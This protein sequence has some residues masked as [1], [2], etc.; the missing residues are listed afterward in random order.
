M[1][2]SLTVTKA[3]LPGHLF[4][5]R[6]AG[7]VRLG[8]LLLLTLGLMML[9]GQAFALTMGELVVHSSPGKPLR[10]S[11][12][13]ALQNGEQLAE[14][15]VSLASAESYAQQ[16]IDYPTFLGGLRI[17]LLSTGEDSARIQLFGEQ[18]WQGEG[19]VLMLKAVWPQ[20]QLS[21]RFRLREVNLDETAGEQQLR[22][23]EVTE[24]ETL[25]EIAMRLSA[26]TN[27]SYL[28]MMYALFLANPE[29][30]YRDNMNNLKREVRLRVPTSSELYALRD[31]DVF[32][33]VREH[34][35][36]WQLQQDVSA[37]SISKDA[38]PAPDEG[39][40]A[41][42]QQQLRQLDENNESLQRRN[43]ELKA[44]LAR[45][46]KQIEKVT[47]QVLDYPPA[48]TPA[49]ARHEPDSVVQPQ[50]VE[51]QVTAEAAKEQESGSQVGD[52][53]L[54]G[55]IMLM[56]MLLSLSGGV[57]VWRYAAGRQENDS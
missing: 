2:T 23:V 24:N 20:G 15:Q 33:T 29:A 37:A 54:P 26:G 27:R 53:G 50:P 17:G 30:F 57:V 41:E 7:I 43:A 28:H 25:D 4:A 35:E 31:A 48:V 49:P 42:F 16:N 14:L 8:H 19:A 38:A 6:S 39:K 3:L 55:H 1:A 11:I 21:K 18:A 46:E 10:A 9:G 5:R 40:R 32:R 45:L 51:K 56:V 13:L 44:R 22:Y 12:S 52:G 36:L 34:Y 47:D